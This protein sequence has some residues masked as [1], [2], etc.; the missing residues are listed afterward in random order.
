MAKP[1]DRISM[2]CAPRS[3]RLSFSSPVL[4]FFSIYSD[5]RDLLN[6]NCIECTNPVEN[7]QASSNSRTEQTETFSCSSSLPQWD[8]RLTLSHC[9]AETPIV[10][11][12]LEPS[13]LCWG[14]LLC[15]NPVV[16]RVNVIFNFFLLLDFTLFAL[17]SHALSN[18]RWRVFMVFATLERKLW[19]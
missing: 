13:L 6:A 10:R 2:A 5:L 11:E 8:F 14:S 15:N 18:Y 17:C 19:N 4:V 3:H 1:I 12:F 16:S 7:R 9:C